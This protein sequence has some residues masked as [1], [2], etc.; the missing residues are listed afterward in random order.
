[1]SPGCNASW[2]GPA[3]FGIVTYPMP[4]R[5]PVYDGPLSRGC[6]MRRNTS[7]NNA[8]IDVSGATVDAVVEYCIV[9]QSDVG[10]TVTTRGE[11]KPERVL[12]RA[13]TLDGVATLLGGDA[14]DGALV[15]E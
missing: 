6:L 4:L 13:N 7:H 10:I 8:F 2:G 15:V 9:R 5:E 1:M 3:K 12:L 11:A 14:L